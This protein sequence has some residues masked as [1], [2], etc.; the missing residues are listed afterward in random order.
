MDKLISLDRRVNGSVVFRRAYQKADGRNLFLYGYDRH[1][2]LPVKEDASQ[3]AKGGELRWHPLRR[4]WNI[5]AVHRQNR[6]FKPSAADDP[7]APSIAG[8]AATEIPF[9]EFELAVFENKFTSLHRDAP[10]PAA[11]GVAA[12]R[13]V[14]RCEV[15]VFAPEAKGSLA[16]LSHAKR[17]LLVAA[18]IDR[19]ETL[20]RD[21]HAFVFP[22]E[23]RGE[24]VGVTLHHPH[25]Q[26]YAFDRTPPVQQKAAEVFVEGFDL[27]KEIAQYSEELVVAEAGGLIAYCPP[28]ARFPFEVWIAPR[29]RRSG[30]WNFSEEEEDAFAFL[31]GDVCRRYD[32][33]FSCT[34]PYMLGLHA[35][36]T[37]AD[38]TFHFTAQFYPLLRAPG[39]LKYLAS[40][41]QHTGIMTVDVAPDKAAEILRAL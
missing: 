16:G 13:G 11:V 31:L 39:K 2:A 23:N 38:A 6:T 17:R 25:G 27:A 29:E 36:P 9:A 4:E 34:T 21:G 41:E 10:P 33:Y 1:T 35:A 37:G 20:L 28:Y 32:E 12:E 5:Y 8:K 14:G 40:V 15:V 30:P 7:L 26:I 24:E 18:W 19:Y 22:F 3:I